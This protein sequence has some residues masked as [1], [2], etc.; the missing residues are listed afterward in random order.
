M[1]QKPLL[2]ISIDGSMVSF[3]DLKEV[4]LYSSIDMT[5]PELIFKIEDQG[6]YHNAYFDI[7]I[8]AVVSVYLKDRSDD[9]QEPADY[10]FMQFVVVKVLNGF[11]HNDA[12]LSGYI[13]VWCKPAWYMF[14]DYQGHA[15]APMKLGELIKKVCQDANT[16]AKLDVQDDNFATTSDPGNTP[17]YKASESDIDFIEHKLLPYTNVDDSNVFFYVDLFNAPHLTS[18]QKLI[19]QQ[20]KSM[21]LPPISYSGTIQDTADKIKKNKGIEEG[22][23]WASIKLIVGDQD[24]KKA[25]ATLKMQVT[26]ENNETGKVYI[27]N[28]Q[29]KAKLGKDKAPKAYNAKMPIN[30]ITMEYIDATGNMSYPNR[31]LPDALALA[32]NE[33]TN[34]IDFIQ[35]EV[36]INSITD[37]IS[38]GDTTYF[39]PPLLKISDDNATDET[40]KKIV[41]WL[42]GKW[43]VKDVQYSQMD[44][45]VDKASTIVNIIRPTIQFS[46]ETTTIRNSEYFY[47]VD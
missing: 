42:T 24:L 12:S 29:P 41:N 7:Y 32:R 22:C 5:L 15:Y 4:S 39:L 20:E 33:D 6:G 19:S 21:I 2:G 9:L 31:S 36:T 43:L 47:T 35:V 46:K 40:K 44:G 1:I 17:R 10:D 14:G 3:K 45:Q 34:V 11:E 28:Q 13:Q 30:A 25:F 23:N 37:G 38:P 26:F 8:G 27:A 16:S 18:F